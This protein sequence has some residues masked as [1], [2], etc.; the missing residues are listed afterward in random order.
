MF[1]TQGS[2]E[3]EASNKSLE[4]AVSGAHVEHLHCQQELYTFLFTH[5]STANWKT[6]V[7][8][9]DTRQSTNVA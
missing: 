3:V 7:Y 5:L 2:S 9:P 1:T 4:K 6:E 8:P